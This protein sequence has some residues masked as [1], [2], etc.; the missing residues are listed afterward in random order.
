M[1]TDNW[2]HS[3]ASRHTITPVSHQPHPV[4][5]C[6]SLILL[7]VG[8]WVGLSTQYYSS[9]VEELISLDWTVKCITVSLLQDLWT[10][11]V[12]NHTCVCINERST[13]SQTITTFSDQYSWCWQ[14]LTVKL[15][16]RE[17]F[18]L[19]VHLSRVPGLAAL[20]GVWL[21]CVRTFAMWLCVLIFRKST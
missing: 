20:I 4:G 6:P 15:T 10:V 5:Q 8:G 14:K 19:S 2:T 18:G 13:Y 7:S 1:L 12:K 9:L 21:F 3:A 16:Y 17:P 11:T